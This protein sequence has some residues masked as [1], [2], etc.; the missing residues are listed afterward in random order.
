[1]GSCLLEVGHI[2][3]EDA[4]ELPLM[5]D[6]QVVQTLLPHTPHESLADGIGPW[7]M[8]RRFEQLDAT[9]PRHPH[10]RGAK[11]AIV[12][13]YQ[14]LRCLSIGRGFAELLG[15]PGI[16]R[17][18]CH[19]HLD[20][21]ARLQFDDE[22]GKE[23][24]KEQIGDLE[25]VT[26]PDVGGMG[27]QKRAPLLPSWLLGANIPHVLLDGSLAD[28]KAQFQQFSPN[29]FSTHSWLSLAI[30]LIKAIV[31]AATLGLRT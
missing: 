29:P 10:K 9:G 22:E 5:Q 20:D 11:F 2:G 14:I 19:A 18:S 30:C 24:S 28:T 27:V 12:I 4:L 25:E 21:L 26:R 1:M 17:R 23:G 6:Q 3:I 16:G 8:N 15:R 31:S 13:S 7:G